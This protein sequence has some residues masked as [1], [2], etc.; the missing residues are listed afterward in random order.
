MGNQPS[1]PQQ[2]KLA[3]PKTNSPAPNL[4]L[5]PTSQAGSPTLVAAPTTTSG[6]GEGDM[7]TI[8]APSDRRSLPGALQKLRDHTRSFGGN[9]SMDTFRDEDSA[10]GSLGAIVSGVKDRISRS[11]SL[12]SSRM[13]SAR[14]SLTRMTS[15]G[16]SPRLSLVIEPGISNVGAT[17]LVR[18]EI[19]ENARANELAL[20]HISAPSPTSEYSPNCPSCAPIRRKSL[21]TPGIATRGRPSNI[22]RKAPPP[23]ELQTQADR[24][25]YFNSSFPN[26]SPLAQLDA[27]DLAEEGRHSLERRAA[28]P[29]DQEFGV[30]GMF[31][32]GTLRITNGAASPTPSERTLRYIPGNSSPCIS[33]ESDEEYFSASEGRGSLEN[34]YALVSKRIM[35][36]QSGEFVG[37]G[38]PILQERDEIDGMG[39]SLGTSTNGEQQRSNSPLNLQRIQGDMDVCE[40]PAEISN[41]AAA[42]KSHSLSPPE[43]PAKSP[44]RASKLA[45]RCIQEPPKSA[46]FARRCSPATDAPSPL[47]DITSARAH[48]YRMELPNSPFPSMEVQ[49]ES[50]TTGATSSFG[51]VKTDKLDDEGV[52]VSAVLQRISDIAQLVEQ[53]SVGKHASNCNTDYANTQLSSTTSSPVTTEYTP[54]SEYSPCQ[55]TFSRTLSETDSG[56]NS[57]CSVKSVAAGSKT[58]Q[59]DS[60]S[61]SCSERSALISNATNS[62]RLWTEQGLEVTH[63]RPF[64]RHPNA[65]RDVSLSKSPPIP[66]PS[67]LPIGAAETTVIMIPPPKSRL[68][69]LR[70]SLPSGTPQQ[71]PPP[72]EFQRLRKPRPALQPPIPPP[73]SSSITVRTYR[74]ISQAHIP[75]STPAD[76]TGESV[77]RQS[78]FL[79]VTPKFSETPELSGS[80][81][82]PPTTKNGDL[83]PRRSHSVITR[84]SA[85]HWQSGIAIST[86]SFR[87]RGRPIDRFSH[88]KE[89]SQHAHERSRTRSSSQGP[90]SRVSGYGDKSSITDRCQSMYAGHP[91]L[92]PPFVQ[93]GELER[94]PIASATQHPLH[95]TPSSL[96]RPLA[97]QATI[98]KGQDVWG[99][100]FSSGIPISTNV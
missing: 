96:T 44:D 93:N 32:R 26:T 17:A 64:R 9:D 100:N 38:D 54:S 36:R 99:S 83:L 88:E 71:V 45:Q 46:S 59:Q 61:S 82:M 41:E 90:F 47:F 91:P 8:G 35:S 89:A 3:K 7:A 78:N 94:K 49:L 39:N 70:K 80:T 79:P 86:G 13:S 81:L 2:R 60:C 15:L 4:V 42:V 30:L 63:E 16:G 84:P 1:T 62:I 14:T 52:E 72:L 23:E 21:L 12:S 43:V 18:Q 65:A 50:L 75:P 51:T 98:K 27:L 73:R 53:W 40:K 76:A 97:K 19:E 58:T 25:Y 48:E 31:K 34:G 68:R 33:G 66:Q 11:G 37:S 69:S 77:R 57:Q 24:D 85:N 29:C 87:Q 10:A 6:V 56:Y 5:L 28:T 55:P 74:N 22:L 92:V 95:G 20:Q 67:P